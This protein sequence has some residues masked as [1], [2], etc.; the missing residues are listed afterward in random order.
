MDVSALDRAITELKATI[1]NP[2]LMCSLSY[3]E[4]R[5]V[6][7]EL[8]A[9]RAMRDR[10]LHVADHSSDPSAAGAA[11]RVLGQQRTWTGLGGVTAVAVFGAVALAVAGPDLATAVAAF[12]SPRRR[13]RSSSSLGWLLLA[14]A[15]P[16][17]A[18]VPAAMLLGAP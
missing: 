1:D 16:H 10:A 6:F 3:E 5:A 7:V 13:R 2:D 17:A 4:A 8:R 18:L 9:L 14:V 11:L 15:V 12:R